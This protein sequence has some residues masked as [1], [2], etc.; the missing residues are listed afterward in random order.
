MSG[1]RLAR[2]FGERFPDIWWDNA[3]QYVADHSAGKADA[4][5][6]H[7]KAV[8]DQIRP[9]GTVTFGTIANDGLLAVAR[10]QWPVPKWHYFPHPNARGL[11]QLQ[12]NQFAAEIISRYF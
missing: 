1:K 3:S 8:L 7:M 6:I 11:T 10:T 4:D 12:I 9:A 5:P 2:A